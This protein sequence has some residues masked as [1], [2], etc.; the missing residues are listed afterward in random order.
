MSIKAI[1]E[2]VHELNG[3]R[4]RLVEAQLEVQK[5]QDREGAL[6]E[7][8]IPELLAEE[9]LDGLSLDDGRKLS[10]KSDVRASIPSLSGAMREKDP[11]R[12]EAMLARREE[13]LRF[14]VDSGNGGLI[15]S[16]LS[17]GFGQGELARAEELSAALEAQGFAPSLAETVN[18]QSLSAFVREQLE[19]GSDLPLEALSVSVLKRTV[20]K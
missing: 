4:D 14:L 9:G 1:M 15:K 13:A 10:I 7:R 19:Q 20:I 12:R 8:V 16:E 6:S 2:K 11:A 5:L 17:V 18:A 3:V